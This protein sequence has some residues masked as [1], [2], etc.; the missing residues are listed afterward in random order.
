MKLEAL[1]GLAAMYVFAGHIVLY[2]LDLKA[3]AFGQLFRFG[4]EAVMLFFLLSGFVIFYSTEIHRDKTFRSYF[5]RRWRR[6]YPTFFLALTLAFL[7][8]GHHVIWKV[9]F[10]RELL[11]N[12]FMFQDEQSLKPGVFI[13]T[14]QGNSPLWSLSYEWWFYMMFYPIWSFVAP[15]RQ[16]ILVASLS[17]FGLVTFVCFPNQPSLYLT[18][19]VIW[20]AGVEMA[21]CFCAGKR[22][23]FNNQWKSL[24]TVGLVCLAWGMLCL[25]WHEAG[26]QI[27]FGV[28]P[29]LEFRHFLA[30]LV[31]MSVG[32]LWAARK[33][34]FFNGTLGWFAYV[35]PISYAL[36][37][38]HYPLCVSNTI[39]PWLPQ[40]G[41]VQ[42]VFS[43]ILTFTLAY[44]AEVPLQRMVN[45]FVKWA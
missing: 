5:V 41:S 23:D 7:A 34:L 1:R 20:W 40:N 25:H 43:V 30:A 14:F 33:W 3:T 9:S 28:H 17:V 15:A 38:F 19:F 2:R 10:F 21:R 26:R 8:A 24:L 6:I 22:P 36:Y 39:W 37:L 42:L 13:G 27:V 12:L 11:G 45:R 4:Q 18:Y 29:F 44:L 16:F 35:A 31:L 32:F